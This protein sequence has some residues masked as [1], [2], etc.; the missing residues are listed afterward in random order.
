MRLYELD[1]NLFSIL[2]YIFINFDMWVLYGIFLASL[3]LIPKVKQYY[4][5]KNLVLVWFMNGLLCSIILF[6]CGILS[7]LALS[8]T[9]P[10]FDIALLLF[11][12]GITSCVMTI[13]SSILLV[14]IRFLM[15]KDQRSMQTLNK[16]QRKI[17]CATSL[18]NCLLSPILC[19][20][21]IF[22]RSSIFK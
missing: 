10:F 8:D 1:T 5:V 15:I 2:F 14:L 19:L 22:L 13:I 21:F 6:C 9:N 16:K 12:Y 7:M 11:T 20:M 17:I 4:L 3:I 18:I